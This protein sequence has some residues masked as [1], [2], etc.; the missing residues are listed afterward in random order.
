MTTLPTHRHRFPFLNVP[1]IFAD[2]PRM[3]PLRALAEPH[4]IRVEEEVADGRYVV[5]AELPGVDPAKDIT[6]TVENGL[7]SIQ[8][9]RSEEKKENGRSEFSYGS[10]RR[11]MRLPAG[12]Q[13]PDVKASYD[14]GILTVSI[15][16]DETAP[17]P[18]KIEIT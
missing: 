4:L 6:V 1:D 18:R 5:R 14:K 2:F 12:A 8:A 11:A 15:G 7:L 9:E 3:A 10:F 17:D 16:L 13:E